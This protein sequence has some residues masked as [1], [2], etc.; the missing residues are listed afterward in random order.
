MGR[1]K[2]TNK[3]T[4]AKNA[5]LGWEFTPLQPSGIYYPNETGRSFREFLNVDLREIHQLATI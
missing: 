2:N 4:S 3:K 1:V 5:I